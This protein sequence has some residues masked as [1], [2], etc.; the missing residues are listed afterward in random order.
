MENQTQLS[1]GF[2]KA[3]IKIKEYKHYE[4]SVGSNLQYLQIT[5]KCRYKVIRKELLKSYC[6]VAIEESCK[7]H[8]IK[9]I[10]LKVMNEHVH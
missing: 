10:I 5:T 3:Q 9:I 1:F 2:M 6:K 4:N 7:R 8:K